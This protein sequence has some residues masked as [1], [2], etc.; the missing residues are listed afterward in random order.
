MQ[1]QGELDQAVGEVPR[2]TSK[3]EAVRYLMGSFM[4][5]QDEAGSIKTHSLTKAIEKERS[6]RIVLN[7]EK[8]SLYLRFCRPLEECCIRLSSRVMLPGV[9]NFR[10]GYA[11]CYLVAVT[12]DRQCIMMIDEL[13]R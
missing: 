4:Q 13:C 11:T 5:L 8:L 3:Q 6:I 7:V 2:V 12:V 1:R 10:T 9:E